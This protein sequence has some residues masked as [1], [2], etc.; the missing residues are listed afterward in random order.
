MDFLA[1]LARLLLTL[2]VLGS[3]LV[4]LGYIFVRA[5]SFAYFRTKY[6]H[7]RRVMKEMKEGD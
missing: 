3:A 2:V 5:I 7:W 1:E 4:M 6:E